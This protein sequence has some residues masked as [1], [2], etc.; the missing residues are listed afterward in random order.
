MVDLLV[1]ASFPIIHLDYEV[2]RGRSTERGGRRRRERKGRER[3]EIDRREGEEGD[4]EERE[5]E[6]GGTREGKEDRRGM[7]R[8]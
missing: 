8:A 2:R 5:G 3:R 7:W 6:G 4:R 1:R